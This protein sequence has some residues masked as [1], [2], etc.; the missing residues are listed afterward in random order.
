ML[1][2]RCLHVFHAPRVARPVVF[3]TLA[4][5]ASLGGVLV[6]TSNPDINNNGSFSSFPWRQ[7]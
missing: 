1:G 3:P 5:S 4:S 7:A 6:V 2:V